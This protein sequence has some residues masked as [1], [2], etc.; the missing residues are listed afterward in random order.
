[1]KKRCLQYLYN[2]DIINSFLVFA[3]FS[4]IYV[5]PYFEETPKN[6]VWEKSMDE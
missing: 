3:L 5:P 2:V 6:D 1:M 4:K